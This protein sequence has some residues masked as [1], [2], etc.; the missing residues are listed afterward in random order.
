MNLHV[1]VATDTDWSIEKLEDKYSDYL[2]E[3]QKENIHI[4]YDKCFD[5]E[6]A[7]IKGTK[8]NCN[9]LEPKL[10]KANNRDLD[11]FNKILGTEHESEEELLHYMR[12]HKTDCALKFFK[13][14]INFLFPDYILEAITK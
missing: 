2:H 3:N 1:T 5:T 7:L 14:Q 4:C 10:F 13:T 12:T 9:T 11:L 6:P 8:Y